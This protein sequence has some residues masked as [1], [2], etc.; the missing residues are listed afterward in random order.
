MFTP[1]VAA[2]P[3]GDQVAE[4]GQPAGAGPVVATWIPRISRSRSALTPVASMT[5]TLTTRPPARTVMIERVR[6]HE[7][8]RP[9]DE[10]SGAELLD[11]LAGL[12]AT[13]RRPPLGGSGGRRD[14]LY[15]PSLGGRDSW[16]G[17]A[18]AAC[19]G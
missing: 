18:R 10:G 7:R 1:A 6:R 4:V 13:P 9:V 17:L 3:G 12:D 8:V 14:T 19:I 11:L 5:A 16:R 2:Q 15:L